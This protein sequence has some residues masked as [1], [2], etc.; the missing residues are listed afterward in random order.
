[1]CA[2]APPLGPALHRV[3]QLLA[4][5]AP[6]TLVPLPAV[7]MAAAAEAPPPPAWAAA[8]AF[9]D[10]WASLVQ[11]TRAGWVV[12]FSLLRFFTSNLAC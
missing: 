10:L 6:D 9:A 1:M 3:C 4:W 5:R 12:F 11:R 7:F 8:P 2:Q